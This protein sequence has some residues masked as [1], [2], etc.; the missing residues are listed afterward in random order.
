MGAAGRVE[1]AL[2]ITRKYEKNG[3]SFVLVMIYAAMDDYDTAY[4][5]LLQARDDKIPWYPWLL[6]WMPQTRGFHD[7]PRVIELA[8]ELDL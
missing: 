5:W 2:E 3:D 4:K 8:R 7:D 6:K 1:E